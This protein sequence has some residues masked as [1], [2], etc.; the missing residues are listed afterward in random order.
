MQLHAESCANL[1]R[2]RS[3]T[4]QLYKFAVVDETADA[5]SSDCLF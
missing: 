5:G 4:Q 2:I 3:I 1:H